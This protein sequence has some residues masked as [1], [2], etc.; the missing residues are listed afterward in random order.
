MYIL[1]G[2]YISISV[3]IL[4]SHDARMAKLNLLP[5]LLRAQPRESNAAVTPQSH[6]SNSHDTK[7]EDDDRKEKDDDVHVEHD[8]EDDE[9]QET[10]EMQKMKKDAWIVQ[11]QHARI[12]EELDLALHNQRLTF[13]SPRNGDSSDHD[14]HPHMPTLLT[15]G[16]KLFGRPLS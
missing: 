8:R 13:H 11:A 7:K 14:H 3:T 5:A 10:L 1:V 6:D 15:V 2:V 9:D 4:H 16:Q 12:S